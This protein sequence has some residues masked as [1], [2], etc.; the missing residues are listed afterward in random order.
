MPEAIVKKVEAQCNA[1]KRPKMCSA[2]IS[3]HACGEKVASVV[4]AK[5]E[6]GQTAAGGV[7]D[8]N[9]E[10]TRLHGLYSQDDLTYEPIDDGNGIWLRVLDHDA[11]MVDVKTGVPIQVSQEAL[12][13]SRSKWISPLYPDIKA[14]IDH[15]LGSMEKIFSREEFDFVEAKYEINDGLYLKVQPSDTEI[16]GA[17][18]SG[19]L[20]PSPEFTIREYEDVGDVIWP[21]GLGLMWEGTPVSGG[22]GAAAPSTI[23]VGGETMTDEEKAAA[24]KVAEDAKAAEDAKKAEDAKAAEDAKNLTDEEKAAAAKVAEDAKKAEDKKTELSPEDKAKEEMDTLRKEM[25]EMKENYEAVLKD[26]KD[27]KDR[28]KEHIEKEKAKLAKKLPDGY[29]VEGVSL[30]TM[31]KDL[32]MHEAQLKAAGKLVAKGPDF[33]EKDSMKGDAMTDEEYAEAAKLEDELMGVALGVSAGAPG[34]SFAEITG[35]QYRAPTESKPKSKK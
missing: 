10:V 16:R 5:R 20:R 26:N 18:L 1:G 2:D 19:A 14:N 11:K 13:A 9:E 3:C 32:I 28:E 25:A 15:N 21:T 23:A 29:P 6:K 12:L 34:A 17:L 33:V 22:S 7:M 27:Q 24:A 4:A 8:E 30:E 31:R 35:T